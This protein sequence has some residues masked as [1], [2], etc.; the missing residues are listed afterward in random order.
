MFIYVSIHFKGKDTLLFYNSYSYRAFSLNAT[1]L[2]YDRN[3][4]FYM[5]SL[6][7]NILFYTIESDVFWIIIFMKTNKS[8]IK[9]IFYLFINKLGDIARSSLHLTNSRGKDFQSFHIGNE[10]L[11]VLNLKYFWKIKYTTIFLNNKSQVDIWL[12]I[13]IVYFSLHGNHHVEDVNTF[14]IQ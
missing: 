12:I 2:E 10:Y 6:N 3:N 14:L 13:I 7:L 9:K 5:I 11:P 1:H 4:Y 8:K